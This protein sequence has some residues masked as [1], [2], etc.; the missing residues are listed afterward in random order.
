[1]IAE[2]WSRSGQDSQESAKPVNETLIMPSIAVLPFT[3]M[4]DVVE[5]DYFVDGL[6]EDL[7]TDLSKLSRFFPCVWGRGSCHGAPVYTGMD[8]VPTGNAES[9]FGNC[10]KYRGN[11]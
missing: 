4:S 7:I 6:T 3:H 2:L 9:G 11:G 5:Q 8:R 10:A 1:M